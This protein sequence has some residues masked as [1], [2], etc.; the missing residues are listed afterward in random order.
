[1]SA[2]IQDMK[3]EAIREGCK[4]LADSLRE[5]AIGQSPTDA[6]LMLAVANAVD[7]IKALAQ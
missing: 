3:L 4:A 5:T 1:M 2:Q 7:A 6:K